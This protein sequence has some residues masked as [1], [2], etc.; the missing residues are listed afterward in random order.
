MYARDQEKYK[1]VPARKGV[2]RQDPLPLSQLLLSDE[3]PHLPEVP[4]LSKDELF[5]APLF[6]GVLHHLVDCRDLRIPRKL[7]IGQK[8]HPLDLK[9]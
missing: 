5:R 3:A 4:L 8:L 2:R 1:V 7:L 9:V 6:L